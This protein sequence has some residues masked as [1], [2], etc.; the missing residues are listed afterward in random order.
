[1]LVLDGVQDPGNAG[2]LVRSAEAFGATGIVFGRGSVHFS[3]AKFLRATAGSIFRV[4]FLSGLMPEIVL[5]SLTASGIAVHTLAASGSRTIWEVDLRKPCALVTGSE[6][7]GVSAEWLT[8]AG[9]VRIPA[10]QVESLNAAVACSIALF[11]ASR[12]R[13]S[14]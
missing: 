10:I 11:E 3:N 4:P 12:Q 13:S 9:G 5:E 1:L 7:A 2:T 6:G 14:L 8:H